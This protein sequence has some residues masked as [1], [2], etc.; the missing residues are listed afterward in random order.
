MRIKR[1]IGI[2]AAAAAVVTGGAGTAWAQDGPL[3]VDDA[4]RIALGQ[5]RSY[6]QTVDGV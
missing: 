1:L 5:N 4:V 2:L 3:T 6:Q